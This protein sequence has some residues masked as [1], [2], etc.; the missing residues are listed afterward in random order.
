[1]YNIEK[2]E[3]EGFLMKTIK[4][5]ICFLLVVV[6]VLSINNEKIFAGG[7]DYTGN[8][9]P[10]MT[11][12]TSSSGKSDAINCAINDGRFD[13]SAWK[14]FDQDTTTPLNGWATEKT[15]KVWLSY[16]FTDAKCITKYTLIS[17]VG[18]TNDENKAVLS[19]C[20]KN[21]TFEAWDDKNS[22]WIVLDTQ[23]NISDWNCGVK[24]V[25]TF[26]N[27]KEYSKYQINISTNNG[28]VDGTSIGELEMMETK[29]PTTPPTIEGNKAILEVVMTNGTIKEYD[30]TADELD[31]FLTWYDNRSDG[32]GKSYFKIPKRSNVKPFLGRN[33]YLSYDKIYS[34]EVKDYNE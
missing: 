32:I 17:R 16:E 8:V 7:V 19:E 9:I 29:T 10:M 20:P 2:I 11:S 33:E 3:S 21:W 15:N 28:S 13:F 1:M 18:R 4:K 6:S 12:D 5:I 30:L 25:F 22:N 14:A 23:T 31:K 27:T 34:F 24:K 26:S